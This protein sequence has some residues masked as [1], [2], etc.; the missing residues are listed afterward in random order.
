MA[1]RVAKQADKPLFHNIYIN[2]EAYAHFRDTGE[3]PDPTIFVMDMLASATKEPQNVVTKGSY[4]GAWMGNLVAAKNSG[5]RRARTA[6]KRFGLTTSS[7]TIQPIRRSRWHRR[8]RNPM[9]G[10]KPVTRHTD[11]KITFGSNFIRRCA[12]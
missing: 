12:T 8:P 11:L 2:P 6:R 10:A 9:P 7:L 1:L 5:V 4:D 3:F